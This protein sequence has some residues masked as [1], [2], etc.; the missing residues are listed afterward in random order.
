VHVEIEWTWLRT[1]QHP[2]WSDSYCLYAYA[3]RDRNW[4]LYIGKADYATV[5]QRARGRHKDE[6]Y[7]AIRKRYGLHEDELRFLHGELIIPPGRRRS[8]ELLSD[9]ESLLIKRL[10]PVAN[11]QCR[12]HRISRPACGLGAQVA[13]H[14]SVLASTTHERG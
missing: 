8:S 1:E 12:A 7:R 14:T 10:H 13:G 3:H 5:R 11:I 9:V 6:I 2:L 4:I